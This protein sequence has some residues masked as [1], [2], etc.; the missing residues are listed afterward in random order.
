MIAW[1]ALQA[2]RIWIEHGPSRSLIGSVGHAAYH[3]GVQGGDYPAGY[4]ALRRIVA[5]GEAR[6]YEPVP[7]RR[8]TCSGRLLL[9]RAVENAVR[10]VHQARD[11]LIAGDD[12]T[13]AG[14]SY[15]LSVPYLVDCAPTLASFVAEVEAG[16]RSCAGPATSRPASGWTATAG[17]SRCCA[18]KTRGLARGRADRAVRDR[19]AVAALRPHLP[20]HGRGPDRRRGRA[21]RAQR[22]GTGAARGRR[23]LLP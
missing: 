13:Y 3:A 9:V 7:R 4:R 20:R 16:S 19:P 2:L 12:L 11:G 21:G 6:G 8:G 1:L 14:Y 23:R 5:L 10:A 17:W 15:Q 18:A 22:R